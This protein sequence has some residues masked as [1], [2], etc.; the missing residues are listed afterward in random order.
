MSRSDVT[1][2][3]RRNPRRPARVERA[4]YGLVDVLL[5]DAVVVQR[6]R[7]LTRPI[8]GLEQGLALVQARAAV[9]AVRHLARAL[10]D[11]VLWGCGS[12]RGLQATLVGRIGR[13]I[14]H[15]GGLRTPAASPRRRFR[16]RSAGPWPRTASRPSARGKDRAVGASDARRPPCSGPSAGKG[17]RPSICRARPSFFGASRDACD[18]AAGALSRRHPENRGRPRCRK[19]RARGTQTRPAPSPTRARRGSERRGPP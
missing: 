14:R 11:A 5:E 18:S 9:E 17:P 13:R 10:R 6:E 4:G 19:P 3:G 12:P 7:R 15:W 8:E 16:S 1:R 2:E